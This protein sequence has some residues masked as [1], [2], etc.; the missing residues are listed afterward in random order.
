M[1]SDMMFQVGEWDQTMGH[2]RMLEQGEQ[3]LHKDC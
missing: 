2:K 3:G 1:G